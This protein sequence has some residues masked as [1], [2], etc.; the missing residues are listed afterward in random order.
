MTKG[1]SARRLR[2]P[3]QFIDGAWECRF[4][5]QIPV[6]PGTHAE[7]IVDRASVSDAAFLKTLEAKDLHKVL[8]EG[9]ILLIGLTVKP[10]NPPQDKL[11]HLLRSYNDLRMELGTTILD[12]EYSYDPYFVETRLAGPNDRQAQLLRTR[13]GGLWLMTEGIEATGL[14]S[15][16]IKLPSEILADP[17]ASVNHA[18]TKLS[19]IFE[20][21]RISHTGNIYKRVLYREQ[22][23]K[24]YPLEVLRN[25]ALQKAE[26][27][28]AQALWSEFMAKMTGA[29]SSQRT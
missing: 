17:V 19:E 3:A 2:I 10:G 20:T 13:R 21:W 18:Y 15:T 16:T 6:K 25:R 7:I 24:W 27:L 8:D 11:K 12:S 28:I 5:G 26:H 22:N 9:A 1:L 14:A 23:G 29:Q 4:G